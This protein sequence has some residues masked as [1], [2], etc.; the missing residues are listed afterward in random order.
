MDGSQSKSIFLKGGQEEKVS[1]SA[2]D[3]SA[4]HHGYLKC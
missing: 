3:I 1:A 2:I 4:T